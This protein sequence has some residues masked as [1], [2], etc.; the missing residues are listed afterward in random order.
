MYRED[1]DREYAQLLELKIAEL[2]P[3]LA[4]EALVSVDNEN[5]DCGRADGSHWEHRCRE[6]PQH[7]P[8][9]FLIVEDSRTGAAV[10]SLPRERN[11]AGER[12]A[13]TLGRLEMALL[14]ALSRHSANPLIGYASEQAAAHVG[15]VRELSI[16]ELERQMREN[17]EKQLARF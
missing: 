12:R 15:F 14:D 5:L 3:R 7:K 4:R 17:Q 16:G 10:Y 2:R 1:V 11:W 13:D 9:H 8:F 6:H